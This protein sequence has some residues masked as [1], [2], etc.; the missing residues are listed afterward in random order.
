MGQI[1]VLTVVGGCCC[2]DVEVFLVRNLLEIGEP[3][4]KDALVN[5]LVEKLEVLPMSLN[6]PRLA[7]RC[8]F[9]PKTLVAAAA[10]NYERRWRSTVVVDLWRLFVATMDFTQS[11]FATRSN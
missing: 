2:G 10:A 9:D 7:V 5:L 6:V 11:H 8:H 3:S 4:V 1:R